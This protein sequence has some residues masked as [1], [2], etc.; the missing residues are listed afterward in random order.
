[1]SKFEIL[2]LVFA[3]IT[4]LGVILGIIGTIIKFFI[5][6]KNKVLGKALITHI[7]RKENFVSITA[8]I[9]L[10]NQTEYPTSV[11]EIFLIFKKAKF[12]ANHIEKIIPNLLNTVETKNIILGPFESVSLS[13]NKFK[14]PTKNFREKAILKIVTTQRTYKYP[15]LCQEREEA[16]E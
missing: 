12:P 15:I 16:L 1:M 10:I 9:D 11:L 2:S 13:Q 3:G 14:C 6:R 5:K 8:D 7:T 4:A